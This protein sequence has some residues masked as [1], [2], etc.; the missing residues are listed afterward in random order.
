MSSVESARV[1][2]DNVPIYIA[3]IDVSFGHE[4][5]I[6]YFHFPAFIFFLL[7]SVLIPA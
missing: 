2:R 4:L 3:E 7:S 6:K 5:K 1:P